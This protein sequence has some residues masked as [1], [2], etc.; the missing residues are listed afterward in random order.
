MRILNYNIS[1]FNHFLFFMEKLPGKFKVVLYKSS[2]VLHK[3][4]NKI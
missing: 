1:S 2:R 4:S 3:E